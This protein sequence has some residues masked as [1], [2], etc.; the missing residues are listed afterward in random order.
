M[1]L[2]QFRLKRKYN[3]YQ[4]DSDYTYRHKGC[5]AFHQFSPNAA[6]AIQNS[7]FSTRC[8]RSSAS[9]SLNLGVE[10]GEFGAGF[11]DLELPVDPALLFV[12]VV[13]P[14]DDLSV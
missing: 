13:R 5:Y 14:S 7:S 10:S 3:T 1:N 6:I 11:V 12:D 8:N 9:S 2:S 4:Y